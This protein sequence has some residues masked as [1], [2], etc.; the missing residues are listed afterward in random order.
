[1]KSKSIIN[2]DNGTRPN[3][4][5][6]QDDVTTTTSA[7]ELK[8]ETCTVQPAIE[9]AEGEFAEYL[10]RASIADRPEE[11]KRTIGATEYRKTLIKVRKELEKALDRQYKQNK[12]LK[13]EIASVQEERRDLLQLHAKEYMN[14]LEEYCEELEKV[15]DRLREKNKEHEATELELKKEITR[16]QEENRDLRKQLHPVG[17]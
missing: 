11:V 16:L 10:A 15:V 6:A 1:M 17:V 13:K 8:S 12:E 3:I 9:T 7:V 5:N 2:I 4:S 14:A